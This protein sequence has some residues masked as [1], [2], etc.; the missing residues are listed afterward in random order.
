MD[1]RNYEFDGVTG[2]PLVGAAV[3]VYTATLIHP[4]V[5]VETS[6]VTNGDGLW[7]F[8]GLTAG[9]KDVKVVANGQTKWYKGKS[10]N[11][12]GF[13]FF[14]DAPKFLQIATP[15]APGAGASEL[16]FKSDGLAYYRSGVAGAETKIADYAGATGVLRSA[17]WGTVQTADIA[18]NAVSQMAFATGTATQTIS[19]TSTFFDVDGMACTLTTTSGVVVVQFVGMMRHSTAASFIQIAWQVDGG[20]DVAP[21]TIHFPTANMLTVTAHMYRFTGLSNGSHIFKLRASTNPGNAEIYSV[22]RYM[23]ATELKR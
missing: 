23:L 12:L 8:T 3:T 10:Q 19:V 17:G 13:V 22:D 18:A 1:I 15:S 20:A 7:S 4:P 9:A 14:E 16:Y 11:S 5:T 21:L 6:G 2:L